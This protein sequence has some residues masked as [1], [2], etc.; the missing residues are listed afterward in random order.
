MADAMAG[1][2]DKRYM[3]S[4]FPLP[5]STLVL[6]LFAAVVGCVVPL[7]VAGKETLE[8]SSHRQVMWAALLGMSGLSVLAITLTS[9][10]AIVHIG[11]VGFS[12]VAT[13][14]GSFWVEF[15]RNRHRLLDRS[16]SNLHSLTRSSSGTVTLA[17]RRH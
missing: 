8:Q 5:P 7:K 10:Y 15:A 16:R 6:V 14:A 1:L 11:M 2:L 17:S 12:L 9:T 13:M 4:A 3:K